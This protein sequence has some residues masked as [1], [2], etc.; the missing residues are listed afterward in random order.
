MKTLS[1]E[2]ENLLKSHIC[3]LYERVNYYNVNPTD[4]LKENDQIEDSI[5]SIIE[6]EKE[7]AVSLPKRSENWKE[8]HEWCL[9]NQ[10]PSDRF[11][12]KKL[13]NDEYGLFALNNHKE[14]DVLFRINRKAFMTNETATSD[15]KLNQFTQ[16]VIFK[17]MPNLILTF[18]L[19]SELN[20]PNSFWKPYIKTLPTS[21]STILYMVQE[22]LIQLRGSALLDEVVKFKRNVARQYAYFWMKISNERNKSFG[23]F[24]YEI[25][26][27]ALSTVMTRQNSIPSKADKNQT[28][29][30][31]IPF[32]D[33]CNHKEGK[34]VTDFDP[35]TDDLV[36]YS[37][38]DYKKGDE[39]FNCY[40]SRSNSDFFLHNGFV[41]DNHPCNT[42]RVK[43]GISKQDPQF[44]LKDTLCRKID[45][46]TNGYHE[47]E[48]KSKGL[49]PRIL[50]TIR[51]FFLDNEG[52][53]K[54]IKSKKSES[55]FDEK[56]TDLQY[57]NDKVKEFLSMRCKL[58]LKRY[59]QIDKFRNENIENIVKKE[60]QILESYLM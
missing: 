2:K 25:Y 21:Y 35:T 42:V 32:W 3:D 41:Y 47:L 45:I 37:M 16:D 10:I 1:S 49:N 50:A 59:P 26:R 29:F 54:W 52:L 8:F 22:D 17:H 44:S 7:I 36:F 28:T 33:L 31:L 13:K 57:L 48:H 4:P 6:I 12:I 15:I 14:N 24:T 9:K 27:W 20:K 55:L 11:E 5:K 18:H 34:M 38:K 23:N 56:C 60:K 30:A 39:I 43:I 46:D 51:I 19:L 40:G 58:L 53:E